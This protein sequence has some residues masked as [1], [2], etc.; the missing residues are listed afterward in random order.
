[1][2]GRRGRGYNSSTKSPCT[3]TNL[4][5]LIVSKRFEW[6]LDRAVLVQALAGSL[7]S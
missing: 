5:E 7:C 3:V 6:V 4:G 2:G 1:M